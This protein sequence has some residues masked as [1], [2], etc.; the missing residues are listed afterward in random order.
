[1]LHH[2][3]ILLLTTNL[4]AATITIS[5]DS[6]QAGFEASTSADGNTST[7]WHS[8]YSPVSAALPHIAIIDLGSS[9][10]INAFT[11]LPRQS[12]NMNGNIGIHTLES[13]INNVTWTLISN[14]T[15]ADDRT[16][17]TSA[18]AT[19]T[20]RYFR[21]TCITEAGN[22]G[23][24]SSAA[25]FGV[26]VAPNL[27]SWGPLISFPLV[28]AGGFVMHDTGKVLTYSAYKVDTFS[29]GASGNTRTAIYDPATGFI[30]EVNVINTQHVNMTH[31]ACFQQ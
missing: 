10:S 27:G 2:T 22:R 19:K 29:I 7:F 17:K 3:F 23:P 26:T 24:W 31:L 20:I 4:I 9:Q 1:M 28:P 6:F 11:Y 8:Q 18:F 25:E 12:G 30:T 5:V 16:L 15:W 13:S 21:L 14:M